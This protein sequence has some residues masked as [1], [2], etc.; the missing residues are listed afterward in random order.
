VRRLIERGE[1]TFVPL[2]VVLLLA[3]APAAE[4][5][6]AVQP[7]AHAADYGTKQICRTEVDIGTRLGGKRICRTRAEWDAVRAEQRKATER[8]QQQ[9]SACIRGGACSSD[10]L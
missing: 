3:Q 10:G 8:A 6:I 9:G 1:V 7:I 2:L 5:A 4:G